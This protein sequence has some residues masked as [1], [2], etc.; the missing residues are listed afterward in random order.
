M[1]S[2]Q[3][4]WH[5]ISSLDWL[6]AA[7]AGERRHLVSGR[8]EDLP[9]GPLV[10]SILSTRLDSQTQNHAPAVWPTGPLAATIAAP[11]HRGDS[12]ALDIPS[13][14]P[15]ASGIGLPHLPDTPE[16]RNGVWSSGLHR[17]AQQ[18]PGFCKSIVGE[19]RVEVRRSLPA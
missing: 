2:R 5:A 3:R 19:A 8:W 1:T 10:R 15:R 18:V 13:T 7:P 11:W 14:F 6:A 16:G 12:S 9:R 17:L 4:L